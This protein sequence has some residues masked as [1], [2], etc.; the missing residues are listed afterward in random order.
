M[1]PD[2]AVPNTSDSRSRRATNAR[3]RLV[4]LLERA[5]LPGIVLTRPGS[6]AW[7]T[8]GLAPP[9][10]RSA[11]TDLAWVVVTPASAALVT[12]EV[13]ADR[14]RAE[15]VPERHAL[16]LVVVPWFDPGAF[17]RAASEFAGVPA[18]ELASDGHRELGPDASDELVALR[19]ALSDDELDELRS[20]GRLAAF[21]LGECLRAWRPGRDRDLDVQ[22]QLVSLVEAGGADTPV[23]IVG[24]DERVRRFRHPVAIGAPM[25]EMA[26]AVVVARRAG[27]HVAATRI[28]L[29]HA[30]TKEWTVLQEKLTAVDDAVLG[31]SRPGS[32]YGDAL[33]VLD[34]AYSGVGAPGAWRQHFQGGPI[35]FEQREFEIA[36][37]HRDSRWYLQEIE[38]GHA[39]AWNPSLAG[40]A[41]VEDTYIVGH[42]GLERVTNEDAWPT[43]P[44]APVIGERPA[45]M[46]VQDYERGAS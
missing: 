16:E 2:S 35:G 12:S 43:V 46:V 36:P 6:V 18:G 38:A 28:A 22:A 21:A 15:Y 40:G 30:P 33:D 9:V 31:A 37:L 45:V 20:L 23:V 34:A 29:A 1:E 11:G 5:D 4:R 17:V 19:L 26:M 7:A 13:E 3:G 24:G 8:G 27:L 39:I 42:G 41:K 25:S 44:A 14:I 32:T 10:D